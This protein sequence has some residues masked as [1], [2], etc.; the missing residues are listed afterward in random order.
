MLI[1]CT[2]CNKKVSN[3]APTCPQCGHNLIPVSKN[4]TFQFI[5]LSALVIALF[6]P[7]L[8]FTIPCLVVVSTGIISLIKK[9]PR[10]WLSLGSVL[11]AVLFLSI[12]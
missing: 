11:L 2:E 6:T 12:I 10:W 8:L 5:S 9:E 4:A 7:K 1:N 3:T